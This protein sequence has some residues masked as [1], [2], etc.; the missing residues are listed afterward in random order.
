[1]EAAFLCII[2]G[3][4]GLGLVAGLALIL[5]KALEF[6]IYVSISNMVWTFIICILVGIIAGII[7]AMQAAKMD[8]VVAIRS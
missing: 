5:T 1:M 6:P 4:V 7:P 2:G 3:L 8:P